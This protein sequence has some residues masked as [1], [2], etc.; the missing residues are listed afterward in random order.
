MAAGTVAGHGD[1]E[2][3]DC[4]HPLVYAVACGLF[5]LLSCSAHCA[6]RIAR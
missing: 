5:D 3:N 1:A 4:C 2:I 6:E